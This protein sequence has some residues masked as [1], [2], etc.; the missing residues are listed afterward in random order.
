MPQFYND[1][2]R[3]LL[4]LTRLGLT[5]DPS[6]DA[7]DLI[8]RMAVLIQL[9]V[10]NMP[11][12]THASAARSILD[13]IIRTDHVRHNGNTHRLTAVIGTVLGN[14]QSARHSG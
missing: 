9:Y 14:I 11:E 10:S 7:R 8:H 2:A 13:D 5:I 4:T 12:I 1:A 3:L 6:L